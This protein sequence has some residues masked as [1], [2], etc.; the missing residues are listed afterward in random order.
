MV[1]VSYR[2]TVLGDATLFASTNGLEKTE[3]ENLL[4]GQHEFEF[5]LGAGAVIAPFE[6]C[7]RRAHVGQTLCFQ[8][9]AQ[10]ID[11]LLAS[12]KNIKYPTH[13]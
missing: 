13:S 8:V 11:L 6:E 10:P 4:E 1:T 5:E 9:P 2:V 3:L 7:V 12:N